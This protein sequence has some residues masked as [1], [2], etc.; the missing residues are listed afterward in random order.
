MVTSSEIAV[1]LD[2]PTHHQFDDRLFDRSS[3]LYA[4]DD[5]LRPYAAVK[6]HFTSRGVEVHTLDKLPERP[7]GKKNV[8]I[9][10]GMPRKLASD[11]VQHYVAL[12][13]RADIVLSA[14]F[15]MECPIVEP[16][17]YEELPFLSGY[18]KR[19]LSWSDQRALLQFTH[20]P[21]QVEHFCWPQSFD[22]IHE[23]IW[24]RG[25]RKFMVI[26]NANKLP[27]L[28]IEELYT[29]R[30]RAVEFFQRYGE[31][32]LYGRNWDK[33]PN[34][35]GKT[36]IPA[37]VRR[38]TSKLGALK[39]RIAPDPIYAAARAAWRGPAKSK[40]ET[41]SQYRFALCFENSVMKG[42]MTEKLFD[43]FFAGTVP[44]YWGAPDVLDWVPP[45]CFID[46][47]KFA[48]FAELRAFLKGLTPEQERAYREAARDYLASS[49]F[50]PFRL[51]PWVDR[52][53]RFVR[54][55]TGADV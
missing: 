35:V 20:R 14:F 48:D 43:C 9:S 4:G 12:S 5:I 17:L 50:D 38:L 52:M 8:V 23:Q 15:A 44:I 11:T 18:F 33:P 29:A 10:F 3:N 53:A 32:D 31:V 30:L 55:D 40:S 45:E 41:F 1:Y 21:V 16:T 39:Q 36:W 19:I 24:A 34:R 13:R 46:M 49:K 42:W 25:D 26:M 2:P 54:E 7:N 47:R 22:A 28:Y 37:T 27:R 51:G 6:D